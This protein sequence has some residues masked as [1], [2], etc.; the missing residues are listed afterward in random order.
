MSNTT[1]AYRSNTSNTPRQIVERMNACK[2]FRVNVSSF[3]S[4]FYSDAHF[5][6]RR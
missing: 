4:T 6:P 1:L 5:I 2:T 3:L